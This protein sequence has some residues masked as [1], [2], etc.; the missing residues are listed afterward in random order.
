MSSIL[1]TPIFQEFEDG[2]GVLSDNEGYLGRLADGQFSSLHLRF[3]FGPGQNVEPLWSMRHGTIAKPHQ[4]VAS[5]RGSIYIIDRFGGVTWSLRYAPFDRSLPDQGPPT[6][7][8]LND[9]L[10]TLSGKYGTYWTSRDPLMQPSGS[11]MTMSSEAWRMS[12]SPG[13]FISSW[14]ADNTIYHMRVKD[15][16]VLK[17]AIG[18]RMGYESRLVSVVILAALM[19]LGDWLAGWLA[20]ASTDQL[21][22][23]ICIVSVC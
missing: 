17:M 3:G 18:T 9:G 23:D 10:F 7:K 1:V 14:T 21:M 15:R 6:L 13:G 8:L 22:Q 2:F 5:R 12:L 16:Y 11:V 20:G 4:M 19:T